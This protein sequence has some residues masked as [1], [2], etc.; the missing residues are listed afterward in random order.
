[1]VIKPMKKSSMLVLALATFCVPQIA[2]ANNHNLPSKEQ[3]QQLLGVL[4]TTLMSAPRD[5]HLLTNRGFCHLDL[6]LVDNAIADFSTAVSIDP[7]N[8]RA[9][10]GRIECYI[11]QKNYADALKDCNEVIRLKATGDA[12]ANRGCVYA[13]S[14]DFPHACQDYMKALQLNPSSACAYDGLGEV[15]FC[16]GKYSLAVNYCTRAI[17][18]NPHRANALYFRG[19]AY[20]ALGN[21][22]Q[23]AQDIRAATTA[24]YVPGELFVIEEEKE[25]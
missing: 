2:V 23:A 21:K 25:R 10:N 13:K 12:Y 24:G 14:Q 7:S 19:R 9:Y 20:D 6:G 5:T 1:M 8:R 17:Y 16:T 15:S 18:L 11:K 22:A 3:L 4:N